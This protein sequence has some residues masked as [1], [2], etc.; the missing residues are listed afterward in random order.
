MITDARRTSELAE[1]AAR[2]AGGQW[3]PLAEIMDLPRTKGLIHPRETG[4]ATRLAE[5]WQNADMIVRPAQR[6]LWSR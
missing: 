6:V 3:Q 1:L 2:G 5:Q 4:F